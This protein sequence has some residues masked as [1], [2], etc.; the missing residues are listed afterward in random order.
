MLVDDAGAVAEKEARRRIHGIQSVVQMLR[1][2]PERID[3][4]FLLQNLGRGRRRRL[5]A[6]LERRQC[7]LVRVSDEELTRLAGTPKHQ[8]IVAQITVPAALDHGG[9]MELLAGIED[10]LILILDGLQDPRNLGACLRTAEAA[11]VDL[12]VVPRSRTPG[13]SAAAS[14]TAAG[15]A[16]IVN[17]ARVA[18]LARFMADLAE[19]GIRRVGAD[20]ESEQPVF[21]TD[22]TGPLAI[23]MGAEDQGLRRLTRERCDQLAC[24]PMLGGVA[25]LNISVAAG[26]CLYEAVRQ[27]QT[28][29][30]PPEG[31]R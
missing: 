16:E 9:A 8:G 31:L 1:T 15:A 10:P 3:T 27:R 21:H 26:V 29:L 14:R 12:V 17:L 18:N 25:S 23:V 19:A 13:V 5:A 7:E 4:V 2:R 11:G 22:L 28:A 6:D 24:L 30:A 20:A